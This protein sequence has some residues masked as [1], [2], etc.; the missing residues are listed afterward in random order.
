M[1]D[2]YAYSIEKPR[3]Q[4]KFHV[5]EWGGYDE[6]IDGGDETTEEI[7]VA[8]DAPSSNFGTGLC[9]ETHT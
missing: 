2:G 6:V 3:G 1:P 4:V 8:D 5:N 9:P 7:S